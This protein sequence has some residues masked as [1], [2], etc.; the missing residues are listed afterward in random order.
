[1]KTA[2]LC[3]LLVSLG[4]SAPDQCAN[5]TVSRADWGARRPFAID[6]SI[7]P[8]RNVVVHHTV[9]P[10]CAHRAQCANTLR[11][12]QNFQIDTLEFPD[13]GYK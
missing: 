13:I 10:G 6:Y 3:L 9:T 2:F 5:L 7:I 11:E 12:I 8:V 1:M 4:G